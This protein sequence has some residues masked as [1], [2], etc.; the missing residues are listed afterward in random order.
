MEGII[1]A[2]PI[3]LIGVPII[4]FVVLNIIISLPFG[5]KRYLKTRDLILTIRFVNKVGLLSITLSFFYFLYVT[6][7]TYALVVFLFVLPSVVIFNTTITLVLSKFI[8]G[9]SNKNGNKVLL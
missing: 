8:N 6:N 9:K 3:I 7:F 2:G 5:I 4:L 1:I